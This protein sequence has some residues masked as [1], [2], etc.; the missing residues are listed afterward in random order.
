MN[1]KNKYKINKTTSNATLKS[2]TQTTK[3][4]TS[5]KK[6][7]N[8]QFLRLCQIEINLV[9]VI[10]GHFLL[11][12]HL[13]GAKI[14]LNPKR[15][16]CR[17]FSQCMKGKSTKC[18]PLSSSSLAVTHVKWVRVNLAPSMFMFIPYLLL[19]HFVLHPL[20]YF[21]Y[22]MRPHCD[23]LWHTDVWSPKNSTMMCL[24]IW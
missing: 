4:S 12:A 3:T 24:I 22:L 5:T 6:N 16:L 20:C 10:G 14:G 9:C 1:K 8:S 11:G 15:R 13:W 18:Q 17:I 7:S 23:F 21:A 2:K 19:M